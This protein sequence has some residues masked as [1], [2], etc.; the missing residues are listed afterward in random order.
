MALLFDS[1]KTRNMLRLDLS[2]DPVHDYGVFAESY[3]DA[4][5]IPAD[6][7]LVHLHHPAAQPVLLPASRYWLKSSGFGASG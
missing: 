7:F 6:F 1:G 4:A 5:E 2:L 3:L